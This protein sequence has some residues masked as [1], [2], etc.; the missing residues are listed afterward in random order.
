M[1]TVAN[2]TP[3]NVMLAGIG[4]QGLVM[5]TQLICQ[6]AFLE[7]FDLKSNDVIGLSQRGGM[8][9]GSIRMGQHIHS[10][11]I[12]PGEGDCLIGLEPLE[13]LRWQHL[14]KPTGRVVMNTRQVAPTRVQ[15]EQEPY[16]EEAIEKMQ[17]LR[18][19]HPLDAVAEAMKCGNGKAANTLLVGC[20][21]HW[22]PISETSWHQAIDD[23]YPEKLR[24]VNHKAW[25]RGRE[26]AADW[27]E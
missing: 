26:L 4:G 5:T 25:R 24:G 18:R 20:L 15:Q 11:N 23:T 1:T 19:V 17:T 16:P 14:I 21:S 2:P 12:P 22:L 27:E 8:V 9:W 10:P 7:G 3:I 6:A 13:T